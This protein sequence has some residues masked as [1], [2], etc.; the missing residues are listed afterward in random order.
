MTESIINS[1]RDPGAVIK[2]AFHFRVM[3]LDMDLI[4]EMIL[5]SAESH[6]YRRCRL[7]QLSP[8]S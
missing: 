3:F 8:Q 4:H 7:T 5:P 1:S 6:H 2:A